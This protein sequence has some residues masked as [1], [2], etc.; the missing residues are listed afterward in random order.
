MKLLPDPCT[1]LWATSES[2]RLTDVMRDAIVSPDNEV[3][4]SAASFWEISIKFGL[5]KIV[6]PD[7]P[8]RYL[9]QLREKS[10]FR[11]LDIGEQAVCQVHRL[12]PIHRDPFDRILICQANCHGLMIA[13]D[14]AMIRQYP[15]QTIW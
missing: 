11:L 2:S 6:L 3:F 9:P 10:G 13:T 8:G 1:F 5:G 14:D 12:P 4:V 7:D 15:V